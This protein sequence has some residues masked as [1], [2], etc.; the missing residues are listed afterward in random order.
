VRFESE[1]FGR[2]VLDEDRNEVPDADF[3]Q[4]VVLFLD[5]LSDVSSIQGGKSRRES[6][7]DKVGFVVGSLDLSHRRIVRRLPRAHKRPHVA[8]GP[9]SA[10]THDDRAL[11]LHEEWGFE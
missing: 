2:C 10:G 6:I 3:P 9:G 5:D 8:A 7:D 4:P 11:E 1:P